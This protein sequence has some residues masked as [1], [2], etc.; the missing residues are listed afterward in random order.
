MKEKFVKNMVFFIICKFGSCLNLLKEIC[1]LLYLE[2]FFDVFFIID[3]DK[4][5]ICEILKY[6]FFFFL[7]ISN[8]V[9]FF[10]VVVILYEVNK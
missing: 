1:C 7:L 6:V 5:F 2:F 9:I 4:C 3:G 10:L 8:K